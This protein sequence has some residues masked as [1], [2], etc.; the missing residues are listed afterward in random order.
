MPV[1]TVAVDALP[2][3]KPGQMTGDAPANSYRERVGSGARV[4]EGSDEL[5]GR[6]LAR[7]L[8]AYPGGSPVYLP[9]DSRVAQ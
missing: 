8:G 1:P 2:C 6:R 7:A 5:A 4:A 9:G 3:E